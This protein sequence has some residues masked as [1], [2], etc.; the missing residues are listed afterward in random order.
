MAQ[1]Q[2]HAY[3]YKPRW[4]AILGGVLLCG[5]GATAAAALAVS[6]CG[7]RIWGVRL[8]PEMAT[9]TWWTLAV[10]GVGGAFLF[11]L[12]AVRRLR[13]TKA[14]VP[15]RLQWQGHRGTSAR[16]STGLGPTPGMASQPQQLA[17]RI[18]FTGPAIELRQPRRRALACSIHS[19]APLIPAITSEGPFMPGTPC[20]STVSLVWS[21][22]NECRPRN[23][24]PA[25]SHPVNH[26]EPSQTTPML[27][28]AL[29][30]RFNRSSARRCGEPGSPCV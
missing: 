14:E 22:R 10:T 28:S 15:S 8:P 5:T 12:L 29:Q 7:L 11:L 17:L 18:L 30:T 2:D 23:S 4:T 3:P 21:L 1:L 24:Y 16:E 27:V 25:G 20:Q 6:G 26:P 19:D 13:G 9:G